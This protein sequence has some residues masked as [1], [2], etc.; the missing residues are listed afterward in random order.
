[1]NFI[2]FLIIYLACGAPFGV[3]YFFQSRKTL[4]QNNLWLNSFLT[5]TVWFPYAIKLLQ[6]AITGKLIL[7]RLNKI[8]QLNTAKKIRIDSIEK[9]IAQI[10]LA[11]N[12]SIPL[13][14]FR[15]TFQRYAGLTIAFQNI[16][17]LETDLNNEKELFRISGNE[18]VELGAKCLHRRNLNRLKFHQ[19]LARTDIIEIFGS[20]NAEIKK[21][22][23]LRLEAT[24]L[25][26]LLN[27]IDAKS[28]FGEIFS[29]PSQTVN[30]FAVRNTEK[31]LWKP[32]EDKPLSASQTPLNLQT[33]PVVMTTRKRE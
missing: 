12:T 16:A 31:D 33:M 11:E 4:H 9:E 15:E 6:Q 27:D 21:S 29:S 25:F 8:N 7:R 10:L 13:F 17:N 19:N 23:K 26:E 20:I 32:R 5:T 2:D 1:M 3:Y 18:N 24:N 22:E 30:N 28:A 14:D